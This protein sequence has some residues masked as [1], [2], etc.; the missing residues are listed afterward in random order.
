MTEHNENEPDRQW[1]TLTEAAKYLGVHSTTLRRWANQGDIPITLTP[2]GH[3]RFQRADLE[4]FAA[5][6]RRLKTVGGLEQVWTQQAM[7]ET[8][9]RLVQAQDTGWLTPFS[10][11][12][13]EHKRQLGRRLMGLLMQY[14]AAAHPDEALL[15]EA[16]AIGQAHADNALSMG[17]SLA[18]ALQI[19]EFFRETLVEVSLYLPETAPVRPEANRNLLRRVSVVLNF[20]QR[21]LVERY[22]AVR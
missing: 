16:Q 13:R 9:Q 20:V 21:G 5:E 4:M 8:R 2:G 19:L 3:R 11:A 7:V 12:D 15:T 1:F 22:I 6:H 17:L 14:L 18:D 10:D